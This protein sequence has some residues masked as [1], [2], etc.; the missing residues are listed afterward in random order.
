MKRFFASLPLAALIENSTL[1][2]HGGLFR[3]PPSKSKAGAKR[4][5]STGN[6]KALT[7]APCLLSVRNTAPP[8]WG[9]H[10]VTARQVGACWHLN[11]VLQAFGTWEYVKLH[12]A[13]FTVPSCCA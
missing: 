4:R 1:I 2:L 7:N 11:C 13:R 8:L 3:A 12:V 9:L 6:S 10:S 5:R